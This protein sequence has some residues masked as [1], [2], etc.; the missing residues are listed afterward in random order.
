M[1]SSREGSLLVFM[2]QELT[3]VDLLA[4]LLN[5][6]AALSHSLSSVVGRKVSDP[7]LFASALNG[8]AA[9]DPQPASLWLQLDLAPSPSW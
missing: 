6:L 7:I 2:W 5:I 4:K 9:F 3:G 8:A 1:P